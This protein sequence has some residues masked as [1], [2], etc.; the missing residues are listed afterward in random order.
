MQHTSAQSHFWESG[1]DVLIVGITIHIYNI[2]IQAPHFADYIITR[3][4]TAIKT[5][6]TLKI[7]ARYSEQ[8]ESYAFILSSF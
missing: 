3:I 8:S 2:R 5:T 7:T 4:L 6:L 1:F